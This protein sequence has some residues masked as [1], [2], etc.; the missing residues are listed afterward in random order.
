MPSRTATPD[1]SQEYVLRIARLEA[2]LREKSA[3]LDA[4][5]DLIPVGIGIALD[6]ECRQI[7]VNRAFASV[8]GLAASQN[9]SKTASDDERPTNF[10]VVD[11]SG[12]PVPDERLPMQISAREGCEVHDVELDVVHE[13]GRVVRLLEYAAPL[14]DE[15]GRPRGC[16]GAFI[17]ITD[18]MAA[19]NVARGQLSEMAHT[20]RLTTAGEMMSGL[21]HEIN[22]PLSA[23][24]NFA[25]VCLRLMEGKPHVA[26]GEVKPLVEKIADQTT[27]AIEII[28]R[29]TSFVRR[30]PLAPGPVDVNAT[31][32]AVLALTAAGFGSTRPDVSHVPVR[33]D[34]ATALPS[35]VADRIQVE[36]VLVNLIRNAIEATRE[37][38]STAPVVVQTNAIKGGVE[39]TVI[40]EGPGVDTESAGKV[41]QPFFTTKSEGMGLGLAISQTIIE[42]HGGRLWVEANSPTGA[43]F[44]FTLPASTSAAGLSAPEP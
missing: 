17:D 38:G 30:G 43:I 41:F 7:R 37:A 34:L 2:A 25:R 28:E 36:Q 1:S 23:A 33:A 39:I 27:R 22:Q 35:V 21:A 18:R 16:V 4:L 42:H 15:Q 31:V 40:D 9:A 44:R 5:L 20:D 19:E 24:K 26:V 6:P 13:D 11:T 12:R 32:E 8:L 10:C 14:F 29:V 3:E